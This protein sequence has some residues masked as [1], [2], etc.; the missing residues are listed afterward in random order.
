MSRKGKR[1]RI[2]GQYCTCRGRGGKGK[3]GRIMMGIFARVARGGRGSSS[4]SMGNIAHVARG[5]EW[6]AR[7]SRWANLNVLRL[8]EGEG[9]LE[10]IDGHLCTSRAREK[11]S[12]S[13]T[14]NMAC[15]S[16]QEKQG[17][18]KARLTTNDV[19][20]SGVVEEGC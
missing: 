9:K 15:V 19:I 7:A 8:T 17:A 6:G 11:C 20:I 10:C 3:L 1:K 4:A 14:G 16:R 12:G 18:S 2:N 13:L 5:K